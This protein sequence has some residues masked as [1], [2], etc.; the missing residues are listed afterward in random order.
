MYDVYIHT[1]NNIRGV[2]VQ[3]IQLNWRD[4]KPI[5]QLPH[6]QLCISNK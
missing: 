4:R 3:L 2:G 6:G 5:V 1:T